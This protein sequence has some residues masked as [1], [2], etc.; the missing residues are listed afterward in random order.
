ME[1]EELRRFAD[2]VY[3]LSPFCGYAYICRPEYYHCAGFALLNP[4]HL[5]SEELGLCNDRNKQYM[6]ITVSTV[7]HGPNRLS[8][9]WSKCSKD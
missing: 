4:M 1:G 7:R 6:Y 8:L 3:F 9:E 2:S 5:I